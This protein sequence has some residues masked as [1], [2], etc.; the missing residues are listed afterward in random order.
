LIGVVSL[1]TVNASLNGLA[2]LLLVAGYL[3]IRRRHRAAHRAS[4]LGAFGCS[5]L[6]LLTYAI[7]HAKA[8]S[9]PFEGQGAVRPVYFTILI[10]HIALAAAV[11]VLALITLVRALRSNL[12]G[13]RKI[14]RW[15]LPIW[16]YTSFTGVLIYV[17]LYLVTWPPP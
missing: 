14:A 11:P 4:M 3:L 5:V 8:G 16:L 1:P 12:D 6:F 7:Y 9:V 10:S 13:H 2:T 17:M 15:T